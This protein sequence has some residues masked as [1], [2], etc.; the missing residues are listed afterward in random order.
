MNSVALTTDIP[1]LK[2]V[3]VSIRPTGAHVLV[4][5]QQDMRMYRGVVLP[6]ADKIACQTARVLAVGPKVE[7][8]AAGDEV[9]FVNTVGRKVDDR[10]LRTETGHK[11]WL[12]EEKDCVAILGEKSLIPC[13]E[14]ILVKLPPAYRQLPSGIIMLQQEALMVV[15]SDVLGI[16]PKV[17]EVRVGDKVVHHKIEPLYVDNPWLKDRYGENLGMLGKETLCKA[18]VEYADGDQEVSGQGYPVRV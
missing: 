1:S 8:V 9:L 10:E 7:G 2:N 18:V 5:R 14:R 12:L 16:G 13:G 17:H 3:K 15:V 6:Y 4:E 11:V